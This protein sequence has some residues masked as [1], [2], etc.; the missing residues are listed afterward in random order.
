MKMR[1]FLDGRIAVNPFEN[2]MSATVLYGPEAT[3]N[4]SNLTFT[5][6]ASHLFHQ[7]KKESAF[8]SR[9]NQCI[10]SFVQPKTQNSFVWLCAMQD[11]LGWMPWLKL[12]LLLHVLICLLPSIASPVP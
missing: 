5:M 2:P 12:E 9:H 3:L 6:A 8:H 10:V 4:H 7:V 11:P 1:Y